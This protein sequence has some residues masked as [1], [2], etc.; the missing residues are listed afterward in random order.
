MTATVFV[1]TNVFLYALDR[2]DLKKQQAAREWREEL[3]K[4]GRGRVSFQ[5]LHEFYVRAT[6]KWPDGRDETRAEEKD[7]LAWDPVALGATILEPSWKLQDRNQLSF[8]GALIVGAA[9]SIA[10]QYLLTEDLQ[11]N[12]DL[13]GVRVI[14]PFSHRPEFAFRRMNVPTARELRVESVDF[15][16]CDAVVSSPRAKRPRKKLSSAGDAFQSIRNLFLFFPCVDPSDICYYRG[17]QRSVV[18]KQLAAVGWALVRTNSAPWLSRFGP[19]IL[20]FPPGYPLIVGILSNVL[21]SSFIATGI[22]LNLI[23]FF[24]AATLISEWFAQK[25][26][27]SPHLVF[28]F[29]LSSPAAYFAFTSYSDLLFMLLLWLLLWLA[30]SPMAMPGRKGLIVQAI[31]LFVLPWIRITGYALASWLLDRRVVAVS[32]LDLALWLGFNEVVAGSPFYF[33]QA[34]RLFAMPSG[35]LF[36]GLFF[37]L[38]RLF[39]NDLCMDS[40]FRGCSSPFCHCSISGPWSLFRFGW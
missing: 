32:V 27:V 4:S 31:L 12:Q 23:A 1:D 28:V 25:F 14:N 34:Q 36:Q 24:A 16:S 40:Q 5:V 2:V 37:S 8:R 39:S 6:R 18:V 17:A 11:T 26:D 13:D 9:K 19:R 29:I 20:V 3:W 33:L 21:F 7:L 22:L 15:R 38:E 30:L 10:C 35:N